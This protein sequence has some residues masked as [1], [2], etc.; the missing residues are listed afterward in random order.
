MRIYSFNATVIGSKNAPGD[1]EE[2]NEAVEAEAA[3][4][5]NGEVWTV[6]VGQPWRNAQAGLSD[7]MLAPGVELTAEGHRSAD[8]AQL[9]MKAERIVI[10]GQ[11]HDLYPDRS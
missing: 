3:V 1:D 6:E 9:L 7:E 5:A 4:E 2:A 11:M 10:D 8:P